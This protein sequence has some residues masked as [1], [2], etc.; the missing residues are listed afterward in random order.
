MK[1][2][3][4]YA[5]LA[6]AVA[7]ALLAAGCTT[8]PGANNTT[9]TAT[10]PAAESSLVGT[11]Q[12]TS[13]L[14]ANGETVRAVAGSVPL[15][16]FSRDGSVT[17]TAGCNHFTA[18]YTVSGD[19]LSIGPT[20]STLMACPVPTGLMD[21]E[22]R[23]FEL[24]PLTAGY[25][26]SGSTLTLLDR[27]GNRI[28]T[29]DRAP[30]TVSAPLVGTTWRLAGFADNATARSALAGPNATLLFSSDGRL[31]GTTGCNDVSGTYTTNGNALS[32]GPLAVTERAC[33]DS[34]AAAR[35][36]DLLAALGVATAYAIQGDR[37][38]ISDAA[39]SRTVE[40]VRAA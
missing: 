21:Q 35:E 28:M 13:F 14:G 16:T 27:S 19:R 29:F 12:L 32:I 9:A 4:G 18:N 2:L 33:A 34:A 1:G 24:F 23:V 31:S 17:G 15:V 6:A 25:T 36:R 5:V 3:V 20:V 37:L 26:I 7:L 39:G 30:G 22:Q 8:Q 11:W 10:V 38:I 40:F